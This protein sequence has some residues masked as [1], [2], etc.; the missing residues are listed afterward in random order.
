MTHTAPLREGRPPV[1]GHPRLLLVSYHFP[2]AETPGALRWEK[3]VSLATDRGFAVDAITRAPAREVPSG[4][5]RLDRLPA[6]CRVFGVEDVALRTDILENRIAGY[7][8]SRRGAPGESPV[9][10]LSPRLPRAPHRPESL[11]PEEMSW[12]VSGRTA[13]RAWW[14]LA[15]WRREA[16]WA[17][18]A[19]RAAE[20][21]LSPEH[22]ALISCGPPHLVHREVGRMARRHA[23]PHVMDL[24]DPW[25]LPRRLPEHLASPLA[26]RLAARAE[27]EAVRTAGLVVTN[28]GP[29]RDA[30]RAR[31]PEAAGRIITVMNGWDDEPLPSPRR[32]ETN[33]PRPFTVIYA[34]SV[35]LDRTPE[36]FFRA[37]RRVV[38]AMELRPEALR[39]EFL[40]PGEGMAGTIEAMADRE[41]V[42][43]FVEVRR[44]A[45]RAEAMS[46]L[47]GATMLLNLS[48]DSRY[49]I[50]SK[51]FEYLQFNA[52]ILV[53][54]EPGSPTD[55]VLKGTG[56]DRVAPQ[57][58]DRIAEVLGARITA[59]QGGE[60]PGPVAGRDQLRR[61]HQAA[62]LFDAL[63]RIL[64]QPGPARRART[65]ASISP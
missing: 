47:A 65:P 36:V 37:A 34:G 57:D 50:P 44:R 27:R 2:P 18:A 40:G 11:R 31:Y 24:R 28:T 56:V 3:L 5:E 19:R 38:D 33:V 46:R 61:E 21:L 48:Q 23:I 20:R 41:G 22:V 43:D 53:L 59:H 12:P 30:M 13:L 16:R 1:S 6:S 39:I 10:P 52:W 25:S 14:S 63:D 7:R 35:Y 4:N 32:D 15:A 9:G 58:V 49:A 8:S 54:A 29:L 64:A 26:F 42:G 62:G 60:R 55:T 51:V 17:R 45:P